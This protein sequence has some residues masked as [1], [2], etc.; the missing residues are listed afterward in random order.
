MAGL[1][2]NLSNLVGGD[3]PAKKIQKE[4]ENT[5]FKKQSLVAPLQSDV[6]AAQQKINQLLQQIG[7]TVYEDHVNT[8]DTSDTSFA[9]IFNEINSHKAV[10]NE[11]TA[12]ITDFASR[13][14][15]EI[16]ILKANLASMGTGAASSPS[17]TPAAGTP[18][19]NAFC[20]NCGTGYIEGEDAFCTGCGNK[21]SD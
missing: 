19:A 7:L 4:I 8:G 16:N 13:Y 3:N 2:G 10:I 14:D 18:A 12:K 9:D 6:A 11:K 15:E 5:E 1:L 17:N 21:L 20:I